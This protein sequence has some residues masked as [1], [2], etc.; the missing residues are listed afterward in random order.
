MAT[1]SNFNSPSINVHVTTHGQVEVFAQGQKFRL[2]NCDPSLKTKHLKNQAENIKRFFEDLLHSGVDL[3]KGKISTFHLS[4][5]SPDQIQV[6]FVQPNEQSKRILKVHSHGID[7]LFG[8]ATPTL[9]IKNVT[10]SSLLQKILMLFRQIVRTIFIRRPELSEPAV[11]EFK[12]TIETLPLAK[13]EQIYK[14]LSQVTD[15][16]RYLLRYLSNKLQYENM[17]LAEALREIWNGGYVVI[18]DGGKTYEL[19]LREL[20][21]KNARISSHDSSGFSQFATRGPLVKEF[22]F[23]KKIMTQLDGTQKTVTW[24][25]MERY[26]LNLSHQGLQHFWS[27][28]LYRLCGKNQGPYGESLHHEKSNPILAKVHH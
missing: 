28:A 6:S 27:Y 12:Q 21:D 8:T 5:E 1:S 11:Q 14:S 9:E 19:W 26:P 23:S 10:S 16:E 24:F 18:D 2:K 17:N 15:D 22:L 3:A 20:D 13:Q 7:R 25:Q 4:K